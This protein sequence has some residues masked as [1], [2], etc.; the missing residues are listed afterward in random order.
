MRIDEFMNHLKALPRIYSCEKCPFNAH[1]PEKDKYIVCSLRGRICL[2]T[3]M[4]NPE[5]LAQIEGVL[6]LEEY[7]QEN[8]WKN[9]LLKE[10]ENK[11]KNSE[12]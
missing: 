3:I 11:L 7:F 10:K 6:Q 9:I 5:N 1:D 4:D 12:V 8:E 2:A